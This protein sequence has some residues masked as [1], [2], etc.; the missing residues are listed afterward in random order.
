MCLL[1]I[2]ETLSYNMQGNFAV[3]KKMK[4]DILNRKDIELIMNTFYEKVRNNECI[5]NIFNNLMNVNWEHHLPKMYDFWEHIL[6]Q[7]VNYKGHPFA[8]HILVNNKITL[9]NEHFATWILLFEH[10]VDELFEGAR[11][12]EIKLSAQSIKD[13]F[14]S[15]INYIN[16]QN[17]SGF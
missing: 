12:N 7:T 17:N 9:T 15:K 16:H 8:A 11:A 13:I 1:N 10:T 3:N 2:K 4:Q 6:F 14:N 5:G